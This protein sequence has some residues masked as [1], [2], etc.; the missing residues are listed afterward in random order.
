MSFRDPVTG[1]WN[2]AYFD[3]E[4]GKKLS[5]RIPG[6]FSFVICDIVGFTYINDLFGFEM[7]NK[8]LSHVYSTLEKYLTDNDLLCR[9]NGDRFNLILT[10]SSSDGLDIRQWAPIFELVCDIGLIPGLETMVA[11]HMPY[12]NL[13]VGIYNITDTAEPIEIMRDKALTAMKSED[14]KQTSNHVS[15]GFY[16]DKEAKKK[17]REFA[18]SRKMEKAL[19][20][21]EFEAY[22]QPKLNLKTGSVTGAE[23]LVRWNDA[24]LGIIPPADFIPVMER[25]GFVTDIDMYVFGESCRIL[26]MWMDRGFNPIRISS[27]F[28][29][30]HLRNRHFVE[31]LAHIAERWKID[32][33]YLEIEFSEESVFEDIE[34][35]KRMEAKLRDAGFMFSMDDFGSGYS[36]M[37]LISELDIDIIKLD[38]AFFSDSFFPDAG[39][40]FV[41]DALIELG[42]NLGMEVIAEGVENE[43]Q[44]QFLC[45]IRCD[46]AQGYSISKP[47]SVDAFEEKYI[48]NEF[49][50]PG[51]R[52]LAEYL[53]EKEEVQENE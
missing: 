3:M 26:R 27:N 52:E 41:L 11:K 43:A 24:E 25:Y 45:K 10:N 9:Q 20:N 5:T 40:Q 37:S 39:R 22:L 28:S 8:V 53:D 6:T 31:E 1:G 46:M 42:H 30:L 48:R 16:T 51:I 23:A 17:A 18:I 35:T 21:G 32:P 50:W 38:R 19:K 33:C 2:S 47:L 4:A 15:L 29:G 44:L 34:N 36:S 14:A 7:G 12:L 13:K 49:T